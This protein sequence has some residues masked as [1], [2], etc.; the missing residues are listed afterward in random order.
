MHTQK[1]MHTFVTPV[2]NDKRTP[3][4]PQVFLLLETHDRRSF[5][6]ILSGIRSSGYLL[7]QGETYGTGVSLRNY[8]T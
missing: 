8:K 6:I 3:H 4:L 7:S 1:H 2:T 5:E